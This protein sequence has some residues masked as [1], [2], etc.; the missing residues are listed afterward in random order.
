M[1]SEKDGRGHDAVASLQKLKKEKRLSALS[2]EGGTR[3]VAVSSLQGLKKYHLCFQKK[4]LLGTM[5]CPHS[6]S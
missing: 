4:M 6:K 5:L 1:L 3:P 2:E